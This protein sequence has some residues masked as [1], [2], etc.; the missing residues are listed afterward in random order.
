[1][2]L[3]MDELE[4]SYFPVHGVSGPFSASSLSI[5]ILKGPCKIHKTNFTL[6]QLHVD[7]LA[8]MLLI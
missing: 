1:M 3:F 7:S 8:D 4:G 2:N 5:I 6:Y